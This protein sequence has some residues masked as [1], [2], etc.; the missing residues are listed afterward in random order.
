MGLGQT[1]GGFSGL[2]FRLIL[3][4]FFFVA[5][6]MLWNVA[7]NVEKQS[8]VPGASLH[9]S[10]QSD[11]AAA[12]ARS[13]AKVAG[14]VDPWGDTAVRLG[15]CFIVA[16]LFGSLMRVFFKT[17]VTFSIATIAALIVLDYKGIID[18][19]WSGYFSSIPAMKAELM[20]QTESFR[21]FV[22]GQFPPVAS[23]FLGFGFGLKR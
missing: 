15:T 22:K 6:G 2:K 4:A 19:A 18:P 14:T 8:A 9:T 7:R 1:F 3:L 11:W 17:M 21:G 5:G 12:G 13:Y 16:I 20:A 10:M 23:A